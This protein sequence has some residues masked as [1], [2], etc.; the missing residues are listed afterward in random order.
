MDILFFG[1]YKFQKNIPTHYMYNLGHD[2]DLITNYSLIMVWNNIFN[3]HSN[4][5][6]VCQLNTVVQIPL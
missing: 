5:K 6:K 3:C 2:S 4:N 1:K